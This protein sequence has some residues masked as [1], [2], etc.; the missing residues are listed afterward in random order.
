MKIRLFTLLIGFL[1]FGVSAQ[2]DVSIIDYDYT[3]GDLTIGIINSENCGCNEFTNID[4]T[5]DG[6]GSPNVQNNETVSNFVI[7]LHIPG[8]DGGWT[9]C[10]DNT[11]H[12]GWT[13]KVKN[14]LSNTDFDSGD[15][16]DVNV[17]EFSTYANDCWDDIL[18]Y[19]QDNGVCAELVVWQ[20]NLSQTVMISDGGWAFYPNTGNQ[21]HSYPDV[22]ITNNSFLACPPVFPGCTDPIALNYNDE[23]TIDDG[24]C[25]Y[26]TGPDPIIIDL[27]VTNEECEVLEE[28]ILSTFEYSATLVNIGTE[29]VTY[30]CLNDFLGIT[31]NCFNG[32]SNLAV[33]IQ[34]GDTITVNGSIN[35]EG[36]WFAGQGNFM[37]VTSVPGEIITANNNFVFY[38]PEGVDCEEIIDPEPC[39]T[40]YIETIDTLYID[41]FIT[42]T[43]YIDNFITIIDTLYVDVIDTLYVEV[44]VYITDTLYITEIEYVIDTLYITTVD[45]V[46]VEV[47]EY[48]FLTDTIFEYISIDCETGLECIDNPGLGCPDWSSIYIPNTFTPNN[49]GINDIWKIIY[50]LNCWIDIEYKIF[51]RWGNIVHHGYGNDFDSYPYWD[52]SVNGGDYYAADGVYTYTFYAKK[53]NSVEVFQR[54]GSITIFR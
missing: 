12:D 30:F 46:I 34:P 27:V 52:G 49:D 25:V 41:N 2:C 16:W 21:T 5:C 14:F 26:S 39:D 33:W 29:A 47:I 51:N 53:L 48:E 3:T 44:E 6:S 37:T 17:Y 40:V 32:V 35:I 13:W 11:Y 42:D 22:D 54:H 50:D 24:T 1:H 38:M 43:L 28:G 19:A 4:N 36:I 18:N 10:V 23:A 15:T 8:L 7:G 20:I 9:E 31:F 45:T